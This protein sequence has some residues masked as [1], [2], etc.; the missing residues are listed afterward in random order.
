MYS[1]SRYLAQVLRPLAEANEYSVKD[2]RDF[3]KV[4][5]DIRIV[6]DEELVSFDVTALYTSLPISRTLSVVAELLEDEETPCVATS[7]S[8]EQLVGLLEL[9]LRS[10][11]FSFRGQFYQLTDGV[12]MGSP[13][14]SV[15]A[16]IFMMNF[17]KSIAVS[18]SF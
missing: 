11:Y 12:A 9:C 18:G 1:T 14:S 13:V 4:I 2:S 7:L 10:T 16:N 8:S 3:I 17:E 6:E 5:E 15:I